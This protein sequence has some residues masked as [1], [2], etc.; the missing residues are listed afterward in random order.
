M[1]FFNGD[2]L[3][4]MTAAA[5]RTMIMLLLLAL[6][7]PLAADEKPWA[8]RD[9]YTFSLE[10]GIFDYAEDTGG[11]RISMAGAA[12][13]EGVP[14]APVVIAE[15]TGFSVELEDGRVITG[16]D[17]EKPEVL[18]DKITDELG[19][20]NE[21]SL[22]FPEKDGL[23]ITHHV[24]TWKV[25]P[26]LFMRLSVRNVSGS[27]V[28]ISALKPA[29]AG[30][31]GIAGWSG[32]THFS[33]RPV[34][35]AGGV[36]RYWPGGG[37]TLA[38]FHDPDRFMSLGIAVLPG[39]TGSPA[40]NFLSAGG[41]WQGEAVCRF[42]PPLTLGDGAAITSDPVWI[43]YGMAEPVRVAQYYGWALSMLPAPDEKHA[44]PQAWITVPEAGGLR[45]LVRAAEEAAACGVTHALIPAGWEGKPGSLRGASPRYPRQ[46]EQAAEALRNAG[47]TPGITVAPLLY[48]GKEQEWTVA[49]QDGRLWVNP[50]HKG[51]FNAVAARVRELRDAGFGFIAVQPAQAPDEVLKHFGLTRARTDHL[52]MEAAAEGAETARVFPAAAGTL[53]A[54]AEDWL[55]AASALSSAARFGAVPGPVRIEADALNRADEICGT[56]MR[57]W[58]GVIEIRGA[59]NQAGKQLLSD[60][61][62]CKRVRGMPVDAARPAPKLWQ[63]DFE[64][65]KSGFDG[66]TLIGFPGATPWMLAMLDIDRD[67]PVLVWRGSDGVFVDV[68]NRPAPAANAIEAH[69]IIPRLDRPA[70]LGVTTGLT[71]QLERVEM[72]HW[73]AQ[74]MMLSGRFGP[75]I[76]GDGMAHVHVPEPWTL[77]RGE[78]NGKRVREAMT[79]RRLTFPFS[80]DTQTFELHFEKL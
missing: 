68:L 41:A 3:M 42:T 72:M 70:F 53:P 1:S 37:D 80:E 12:G 79:G 31:G 17:I 49:T 18:R 66:N 44:P 61:L 43:S 67:T 54:E 36:P 77:K 22:V 33:T 32:K 39:G 28:C 24:K 56:A 21:Y 15:G 52:A 14:G 38:L 4:N 65:G 46:I 73:D 62:R 50:A 40:I 16:A 64:N 25:R 11:W 7:M 57:L 19:D 26:F 78:T 63:V 71:L 76:E 13:A 55:K 60:I 20:G 45:D 6:S 29:V 58:P 10:K 5:V 30:A 8:L 47:F 59:L 35:M 48:D 34:H 27:P 75:G 9:H 69:T 23:I 74:N 51:G 2:F